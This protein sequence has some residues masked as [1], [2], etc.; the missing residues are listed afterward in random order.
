MPSVVHGAAA[1]DGWAQ[2]Y[3]DSINSFVTS[4]DVAKTQKA[5]AQGCVDASVCK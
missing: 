1:K 5:L 4:L 2:T 3:Q